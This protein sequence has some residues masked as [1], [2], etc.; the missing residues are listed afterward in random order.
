MWGRWDWVDKEDLVSLSVGGLYACGAPSKLIGT[1][2]RIPAT[3]E[4]LCI[5]WAKDNQNIYCSRMA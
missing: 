1:I 2:F 3:G 5:E 4:G